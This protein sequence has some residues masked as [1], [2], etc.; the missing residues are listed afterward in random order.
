[1]RLINADL[2]IETIRNSNS[3]GG[4][5][6]PVVN[7]IYEYAIKMINTM[8]TIEERPHGKWIRRRYIKGNDWNKSFDMYV[9]SNCG[10]EFS[11]DAET[12]ISIN[13]YN[14]CPNCTADMKENKD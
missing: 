14:T 3:M 6:A 8:P 1:M 10:E 2:L 7:S 13:N 12:G 5:M 4:Y 9:C 11:Y